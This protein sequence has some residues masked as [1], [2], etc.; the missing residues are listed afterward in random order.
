MKPFGQLNN[1]NIQNEVYIEG[2]NNVINNYNNN[3]GYYNNNNFINYNNFINNNN[4]NNFI[5]NNNYNN[6]NKIIN[7]P[8]NI[9]EEAFIDKLV[10]EENKDIGFDLKLLKRKK[11][12]VNLIHFDTNLT[13]KENYYFFCKFK[14]DVV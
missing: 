14:V 6:N 10:K 5:N 12:D 1:I 9:I 7:K 2:Q 4:Y 8:S 13:N 11:L 3:L